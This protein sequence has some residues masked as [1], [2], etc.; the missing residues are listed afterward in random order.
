LSGVP[1]AAQISAEMSYFSRYSAYLEVFI[2][3]REGT[4][5]PY[6][7]PPPPP[8]VPAIVRP[9]SD[10][11]GW[12]QGPMVAPYDPREYAKLP[13]DVR[14]ALESA[15]ETPS[16][17]LGPLVKP[18]AWDLWLA[19][20]PESEKV[21]DRRSGDNIDMDTLRWRRAHGL[22]PEQQAKK[23]L[24]QFPPVSE[25]RT[26]SWLKAQEDAWIKAKK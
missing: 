9:A 19:D 10:F 1:G 16:I 5:V 7:M 17:T 4:V 21:E 15:Q 6:D 25:S 2:P 13:Y 18:E 26:P 8:D 23:P 20:L 3:D 12:S 24:V 11:G 14:M 22:L